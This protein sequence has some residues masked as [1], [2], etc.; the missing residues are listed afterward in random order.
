MAGIAA[1]GSA[2]VGCAGDD[3]ER[4][5]TSTTRPASATSTSD[6]SA[7]TAAAKAEADALVAVPEGAGDCGVLAADA[8]W[9]TT[10]IAPPSGADCLVSALSEH[11]SAVMTFR[12]RT[13]DGG[14]LVTEYRVSE[15]GSVTVTAHL[16]DAS[17]D[18]RT[19]RSDCRPPTGSW[20]VGVEGQ[21]V[22]FESGKAYC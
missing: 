15:G 11:R 20:S 7:P 9:P 18:V 21:L 14:A 13:G 8:G 5:S 2:N 16:V 4:S 12:G 3:S 1:L 17:G 19:S 22:H 6:P 10:T